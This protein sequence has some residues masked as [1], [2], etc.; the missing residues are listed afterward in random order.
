VPEETPISAFP[1]S[2][3]DD[4]PPDV[5]RLAARLEATDGFVPNL[6]RAYAWRPDRLRAWFAHYR[7]LLEPTEGLSLVDREMIAVVVSAANEC[8]YCLA[9]H[10]WGLRR[11]L[12][13]PST[14]DRVARDHRTAGLDDRLVAILDYAQKLSRDPSSG[15]DADIAQLRGHGLSLTDMWDVIELTAMFNFTN[16]LTTAAG[17]VLN[18]E[19]RRSAT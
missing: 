11:A 12:D 15:D 16:R 6:L 14:A 4:W 8:A 17:I 1:V 5:E 7:Q 19:Y 13:D 10:G 2:D 3:R 9:S 18:D